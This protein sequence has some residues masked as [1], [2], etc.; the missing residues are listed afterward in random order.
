MRAARRWSIRRTVAID[1]PFVFVIRDHATG[2]LV[3]MGRVAT[4]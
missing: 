4:P 2:A 1:R 3:F